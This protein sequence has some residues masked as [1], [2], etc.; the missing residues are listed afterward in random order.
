MSAPVRSIAGAVGLFQMMPYTAAALAPQLG[1]AEPDEE[2]LKQ[3]AVSAAL[4]A[5]FELRAF[6]DEV[7]RHG[8]IPL[9]ILSELVDAWIADRKKRT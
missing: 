1:L 3:P 6:H 7:L 2:A 9:D 5:R 4:G 8:A